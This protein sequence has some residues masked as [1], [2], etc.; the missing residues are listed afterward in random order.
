MYNDYTM[1]TSSVY[2]YTYMYSVVLFGLLCIF[3]VVATIKREAL[4]NFFLIFTSPYKEFSGLNSGKCRHAE[5]DEDLSEF[6]NDGS[7]K[8]GYIANRLAT[9]SGR[10]R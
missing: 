1:D 8:R 3:R 7:W 2:M 6:L 9:G 10:F 4:P 5:V